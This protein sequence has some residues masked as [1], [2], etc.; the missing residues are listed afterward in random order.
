MK[1]VL[2]LELFG[3]DT[4]QLCKIYRGI[5]TVCGGSF[6]QAVYD[7]YLGMP[8]KSSWVA[9][10]TGPD[11]KYGL[12]RVFLKGKIDYSKSN[13]KG[14][15]GIFAEY[16]LSPGKIYEVKSQETWR[17]CRR[18]FCIVGDSGEIV[19]LDESTACHAVG[20]MTYEERRE[21]RFA[22]RVSG[23]QCP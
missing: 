21:K 7:T 12:S 20:A 11:E 16:I 1:G 8:P 4:R 15:R 18:Y 5:F 9:E 17:R 2:I 23:N 22:E 3:E 19:E 10:I 13:G 14:S 6:G